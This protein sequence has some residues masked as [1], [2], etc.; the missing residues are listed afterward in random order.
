MATYDLT[1][2]IP[3][4]STPVKGDMLNYTYSRFIKFIQLPA[5]QYK[6]ECWGAQGGNGSATQ[7]S[8]INGVGGNG[9]YAKGQLPLSSETTLY[10]VTGGAG[11][12]IVSGSGLQATSG[13]Y[14]GGEIVSTYGRFKQNYTIYL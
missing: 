7:S 5:G 11:R 9:G 4:A 1:A 6:L 3:V 12:S 2:S 8:H 14:K 13:G 10:V